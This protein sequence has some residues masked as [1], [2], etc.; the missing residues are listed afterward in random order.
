MRAR[1]VEFQPVV[2]G[3]A[4]TNASE[5]QIIVVEWS[6]HAALRT[7]PADIGGS[8]QR[9]VGLPFLVAGQEEECTQWR[10]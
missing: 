8:R 10:Y 3:E 7:H 5:G 4:N 1:P 6:T 9:E 2:D